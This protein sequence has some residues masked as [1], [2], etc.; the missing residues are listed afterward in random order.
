MISIKEVG[1]KFVLEQ[2]DSTANGGVMINRSP[3]FDRNAMVD[4]LATILNGLEGQKQQANQ[5][6]ISINKLIGEFQR[7]MIDFQESGLAAEAVKEEADGTA[8]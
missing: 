3:D 5:Q 7:L 8:E 6:I 2:A 4:H 1:D